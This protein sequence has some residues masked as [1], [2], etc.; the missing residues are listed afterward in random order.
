MSIANKITFKIML[1]GVFVL[2]VL[3]I[4]HRQV[5]D[6]YFYAVVLF[7]LAFIMA[8]A[9]ASADHLTSPFKHFLKKAEALSNGDFAGRFYA[10]NKDELEHLSKIFNKIAQ[11]L[12]QSKLDTKKLEQL[13][14]EKVKYITGLMGET[15]Y[16]LEQKVKNRAVEFKKIAYSFRVLEQELKLKELEIL[17]L[18]KKISRLGS[19]KI[20]K[21]A[22]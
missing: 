21:R 2:V 22:S 6:N 16:A 5:N 11:N 10:E 3:V 14:D 9:I 7:L 1:A 15:I 13:F 18:K 19:K 8:F 17:S 12:G 20:K 4:F